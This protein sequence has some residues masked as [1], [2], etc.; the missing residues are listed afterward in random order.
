MK[1]TSIRYEVIYKN[2]VRDLRKYYSQDFNHMKMKRIKKLEASNFTEVLESYIKSQFSAQL[3]SLKI[4]TSDLIFTLGSL[5]YPKLMLKLLKN[6][7][8]VKVQVVSIYNY[9]YKFSLERLQHFLNN[10]SLMLLFVDYLR[11]NGFSRIHTSPNMVKYRHA[12]YEACQVM[13]NQSVHKAHLAEHY[14][15]QAIF[16]APTDHEYENEIIHHHQN[17]PAQG[18]DGAAMGE[19]EDEDDIDEDGEGLGEE[20]PVIDAKDEAAAA[21]RPIALESGNATGK[22]LK[23]VQS[24]AETVTEEIQMLQKQDSVCREMNSSNQVALPMISITQQQQ[25]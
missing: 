17:K 9:L 8:L 20:T 21:E 13:I 7:A 24:S 22:N 14:D 5:I 6:N 18:E 25:Q 19:E 4:P 1:I 11:T 23:N 2:L 16:R 15:I 12:Y 3:S 10:E